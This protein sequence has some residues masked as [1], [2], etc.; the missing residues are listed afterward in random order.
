MVDI[1]ERI[2]EVRAEQGELDLLLSVCDRVLGKCLCPLGDAAAMPV[3][4]Y[5]AKFREEYQ[6]HIDEGACPFAGESSL[7]GLV[8]PVT[9]HHHTVLHTIDIPVF[10]ARVA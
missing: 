8:A 1:L 3:A 6:R 5:V 7:E 2:E 10:D 4:S 9:Q